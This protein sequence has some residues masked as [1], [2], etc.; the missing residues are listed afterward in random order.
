MTTTPPL[1]QN[2]SAPHQSLLHRVLSRS[3]ALNLLIVALAGVVCVLGYGLVMHAVVRPPVE[4]QRAGVTPL[5]AGTTI[6]VDVL[7]GCG[8]SGSAS[9]CTSYLRVRG[10]DVVEV[11]NYKSF[12]VNESLVVD[13]TGNLENALRV[14]YALGIS[15]KN[16]V[17]QINPDYYVDVSVVIGRDFHTLQPSH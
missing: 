17:Q 2:G 6:Q 13:R 7:N 5:P 1:R 16:V 10:F 8:V 4:S 14:A 3:L 15:R 9:Q 11:R 12:D